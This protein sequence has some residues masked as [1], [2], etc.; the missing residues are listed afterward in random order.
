MCPI[1]FFFNTVFL[2]LCFYIWVYFAIKQIN[3]AAACKP[4]AN[5]LLLCSIL[6]FIGNI[7]T[8]ISYHGWPARW[9]IP[10]WQPALAF[11]IHMYIFLIS[12]KL[13]CCC[14]QAACKL[15]AYRTPLSCRHRAIYIEVF[16]KYRTCFMGV[17]TLPPRGTELSRNNHPT[18]YELGVECAFEINLNSRCKQFFTLRQIIDKCF[19]LLWGRSYSTRTI[20]KTCTYCCLFLQCCG[21]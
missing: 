14:L 19:C 9:I 12:N 7:V 1:L 13:C 6:C 21:K 16:D 18:L 8:I 3:S 11:Y 5:F 4:L 20:T 10:F 15:L 17:V 2:C